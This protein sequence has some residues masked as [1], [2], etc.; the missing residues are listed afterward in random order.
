MFLYDLWKVN[1]YL[2]VIKFDI[3]KMNME[4]INKN[5]YGRINGFL[6]SIHSDG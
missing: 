2:R 4:K 6:V 1:V 3:I 5:E